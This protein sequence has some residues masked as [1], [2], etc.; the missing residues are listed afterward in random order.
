MA[1]KRLTEPVIELRRVSVFVPGRDQP[2][3]HSL[4]GTIYKGEWLTIAGKNGSGKSVLA[5]LLAGLDGRYEG[6][7]GRSYEGSSVRLVMQNPEAQLIGE[8]VHEDILFGMECAGL[9]P[10][11]MEERMEAALAAAG[12]EGLKDRPVKRLSGG[13]KQLLAIAGALAVQPAVLVADEATS[14]LDPQSRRSLLE[15]LR[16]L[17]TRGI[18]IVHITQ[19]LEEAAYADRLWALDG[20]ELVY[21]G[22]PAGFFYG[23]DGESRA[24]GSPCKAA[25]LHPPLA[26]E[27]A[28]ELRMQGLLDGRY[29]LTPE[30]L[31]KA[32][33]P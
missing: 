4:S 3:L 16:A 31:E 6:E 25:G 14:M 1:V 32:V 11:E 23:P 19:L 24:E 8:T 21:S 20:G 5:R 27:I 28:W 26:V 12:L 17:Q 18:T 30:E 13:Q 7:M 15:T 29:P 33:Q 10:G 2:V 22:D 9:P